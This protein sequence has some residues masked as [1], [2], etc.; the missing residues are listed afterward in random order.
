MSP[1]FS[2]KMLSI[3]M[4]TD[5]GNTMVF[6]SRKCFAINNEDPNIIVE[7]GVKDQK[8]GLYQLQVHFVKCSTSQHVETYVGKG[9]E[10]RNAHQTMFWH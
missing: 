3:G 9:V 6:H 8:N 2:K 5:K 7:K 10:I 1:S 4:I